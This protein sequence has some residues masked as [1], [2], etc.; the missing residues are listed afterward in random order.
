MPPLANSLGILKPLGGG[1]PIPLTKPELTLGRRPTCDICLDFDNISGKHCVL[2]YIE[3]IWHVRDLGSTNGTTLN[4]MQI[5]SDHSVMPDD[6]VGIAGHFFMFD[7]DPG[8]PDTVVNKHHVLEDDGIEAPKKHSLMELAGLDTDA[9]KPR[10]QGRPQRAPALIERLSAE[11]AE[12]EDA[13]PEHAK[14]APQPVVETNEDEF[15][16]MIQ[17]DVEKPK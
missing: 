3:G 15:L 7:Y 2:R 8:G 16:K 6:E 1:D 4:G 17:E 5:V 11:E 10:R 12:F 9:N 14:K 13:L